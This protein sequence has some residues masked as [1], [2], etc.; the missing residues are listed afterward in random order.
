MTGPTTTII[1]GR[2]LDAA[3]EQWRPADAA[4]PSPSTTASYAW[5]RAWA[6]HYGPTVDLRMAVRRDG[7]RPTGFL[8]M[9]RSRNRSAGPIPLRTQHV[10][11][12][13]EPHD[14]GV[15]VE[16][17]R[18][19]TAEGVCEAAFTSDAI[20][21][22]TADTPDRLDLDGVTPQLLDGLSIEPTDMEIRRSPWHDTSHGDPD[23][24]LSALGK[25]S[26]K[27]LKRRLKSYPGLRAEWAADVET[28]LAFLAELMPM[29]QARWQA[30]G[31]AGAFASPRFAGFARDLVRLSDGDDRVT[32]SRV[33][34]DEGTVGCVL[35][36][37]QDGRVCDFTAGFA[38]P[39]DRPSPGLVAHFAN[40]QE[41]ARRGLAGYEFLVGDARVKQDLSTGSF[42]LVWARRPL[43]TARMTAATAARA[44][45]RVVRG[46]GAA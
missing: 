28:G 20:A 44:I 18:P 6:T 31:E 38:S 32:V 25:S 13:G 23:A 16:Y 4:C 39:D 9:P 12:A 1:R 45:V 17:A 22:A 27:N 10:G 37:R 41:A 42:D 34:D 7:D 33:S 36:L 11:T 3:F 24:V 21:A 40:I 19:W 46:Q 5:N 43:G 15:F 2:D 14:D 26:R 8:L 29:H 30:S 35:L